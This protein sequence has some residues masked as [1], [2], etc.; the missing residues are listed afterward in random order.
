M[1][2]SAILRTTRSQ[3][4][5]LALLI[6]IL[7]PA[8]LG[9]LNSPALTHT[10]PTPTIPSHP[11]HN[12]YSPNNLPTTYTTPSPPQSK[13]QQPSLK[14]I[15][16]NRIATTAPTVTN[17][18]QSTNPWGLT[19]LLPL[20]AT[21]LTRRDRLKPSPTKPPSSPSH[22]KAD[23]Y[24]D[25]V[26]GRWPSR[27]PIE[28]EGGLNLYAFLGNNGL[29]GW[30]ALGLSKIGDIIAFFDDPKKLLE[31]KIKS[32]IGKKVPGFNVATIAASI[33]NEMAVELD[34][35]L[36]YVNII[37]KLSLSLNDLKII[38]ECIIDYDS[39][40]TLESSGNI[41]ALNYCLWCNEYTEKTKYAT[42]VALGNM[43]P[44][45]GKGIAKA[46]A[47]V[48]VGKIEDRIKTHFDS[49]GYDLTNHP[50]LAKDVG[51][52]LVE[53]TGKEIENILK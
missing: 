11:T 28:E 53:R 46:L 12:I 31:S 24:N 8:I 47:N 43:F 16:G 9:S 17:H 19:A 5:C 27:D 13:P 26:V 21:R 4:Y 32:F 14:H 38:N 7:C 36:K 51:H 44:K 22:H 3:L 6:G 42:L 1:F 41:E 39:S 48:A 40:M 34:K 23:L 15:Y 33:G 49:T 2:S 30:D 35:S 29:S 20:L 50:E 52:Y 37:G 10:H 18:P 45:L 25:P